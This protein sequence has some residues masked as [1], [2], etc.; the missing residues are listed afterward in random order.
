MLPVLLLLADAPALLAQAHERTRAER[1]CPVADTTDVTVCGR[2]RADRYR[3]SFVNDNPGDPRHEGVP[4]ERERLLKKRSPL[5]E[6]G[7]F[8][9]GGGMVGVSASTGRG[10]G[11]RLRPLAP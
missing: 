2:R 11:T 8:L 3:V 7:P 5:E 1:P 6:M 4:A 9:V 10:Q